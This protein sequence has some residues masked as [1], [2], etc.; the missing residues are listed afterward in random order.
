MHTIHTFVLIIMKWKQ[1][2]GPSMHCSAMDAMAGR[3]ERDVKTL[4][5]SAGLPTLRP[6]PLPYSTS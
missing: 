5:G 1:H 2:F 3:S 4:T 6:L